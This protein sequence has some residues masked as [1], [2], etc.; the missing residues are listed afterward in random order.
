MTHFVNLWMSYSWCKIST[1]F[2]AKRGAIDVLNG[3]THSCGMYPKGCR[4]YVTQTMDI[5]VMNISIVST[6]IIIVYNKLH[7]S[8]YFLSIYI[9]I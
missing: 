6:I 1:L 2:T 8:S 4:K 3:F 5:D 7:F 9:H